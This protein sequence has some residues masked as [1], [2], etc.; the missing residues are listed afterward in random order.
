MIA[1]A[2]RSASNVSPSPWRLLRVVFRFVEQLLQ[3]R[4]DRFLSGAADPFVTDDS[5]AI[6]DIV[7]RRAGVPLRRDGSARN[8]SPGHL[9]L[10]HH[11][12]EFFRLVAEDIDADQGERLLFHLLDERPLVGPTGASRQSVFRPEIE[13]H[14]LPAVVAQFEWLA[15]LILAIN[16]L[17]LLADAKMADREKLRLGLLADRATPGHFDFAI[18]RLGLFQKSFDFLGPTVA[19]FSPQFLI[20]ALAQKRLVPVRQ[21]RPVL[22]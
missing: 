12:F 16:V 11:L 17:G 9:L 7:R 3:G 2:W 13:Q 21:L 10:V 8:G 14:H 19:P 1:K 6:E 4:V 15:V 20:V 22:E 18:F 5:L